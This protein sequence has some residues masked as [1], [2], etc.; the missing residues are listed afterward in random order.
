MPSQ[1]DVVLEVDGIREQFPH[2]HLAL[3][4]LSAT[5]EMSLD[6]LRTRIAGHAIVASGFPAP[7]TAH[8]QARA[9]HVSQS[10]F[11]ATALRT[12]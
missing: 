12:G 11:S 5:N 2:L 1:S 9:A 8:P 10:S 7:L 4:R 3:T 6:D